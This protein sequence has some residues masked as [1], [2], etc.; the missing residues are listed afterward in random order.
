MATQDLNNS[1]WAQKL[2][3]FRDGIPLFPARERGPCDGSANG[4]LEIT[5]HVQ[6]NDAVYI[7]GLALLVAKYSARDEVLIAEHTASEP[8]KLSPLFYRCEIQRDCRVGSF[9]GCVD[10]EIQMARE[11][12]PY[13]F[14]GVAALLGLNEETV[15]R[16]G[17]STASDADPDLLMP[18]DGMFLRIK[19]D[20]PRARLAFSYDA[21]C[22]SRNWI[23]RFGRHY[24]RVLNFLANNRSARLSELGLLSSEEEQ[25]ITAQFNQTER[26]NP[27]SK[28][29]HGLVEERAASAHG[30]VAVIFENEKLTYRD[31]NE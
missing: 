7:G 16:I 12:Q 13:S 6:F 14:E 2:Y 29:L 21:R 30:S 25:S 3:Q 22:Y 27:A 26:G 11:H 17:F 1:Y 31:L 5:A 24:L 9:L 4:E 28:T 8:A 10:A 18:A 19:G 15:C 20:G 23:E